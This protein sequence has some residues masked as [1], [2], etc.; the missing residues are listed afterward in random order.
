MVHRTENRIRERQVI[1]VESLDFDYGSIRALFDV[2]FEIQEGSV[3]ALVGPN[4]SGKTTLMRTIAGLQTPARGK[5]LLNGLDVSEEPRKVHRQIGFLP[6]FFGLYDDLLVRHSLEFHAG[7]K[8]LSKEQA[9]QAIDWAATSLGLEFRDDQLVRELSRGNRQRLAIAQAILHRPPVA[10]LDEP[11]SGLDPDARRQLSS[12]I[13]GLRD[14]GMTLIVSSH[15]LRELEDYATHVMV[16]R[17]G[18]MVSFEAITEAQGTEGQFVEI[19]LAEP[20]E[21]LKDVLARYEQLTLVSADDRS[22]RVELQ[23]QGEASKLL[24]A[25]VAAGLHVQRFDPQSR[26]VEQVYFG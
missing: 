8:K 26:S 5:L 16:L 3:V 10:L 4:G 7:A 14:S 6:D 22:A 23:A 13:Q 25:L 18:R 1:R 9:S 17:E 15:I 19:V 20:S 12:L 11:A 21:R 24:S 2:N